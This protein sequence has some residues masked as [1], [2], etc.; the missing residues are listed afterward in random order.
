MASFLQDIGL[1]EAVLADVA[2][3]AAGQPVGTS[4]TIGADLYDVAVVLLPAGP[5]APYSEISGS[6]W[7][8]IVAA[9]TYAATIAAG[10]TLQLAIKENKTWYGVTVSAKPK[11]STI[12][13]VPFVAA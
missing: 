2:G 10:G 8:I 12:A 9:L 11:G 6:F 4:V 7:S 1:L 13:S 5:V 3:F